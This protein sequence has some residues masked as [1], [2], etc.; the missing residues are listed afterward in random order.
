MKQTQNMALNS[1][2]VVDITAKLKV[3][4]KLKA[5]VKSKSIKGVLCDDVSD[6]VHRVHGYLPE[7][8]TAK[9][10]SSYLFHGGIQ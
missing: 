7:K 6:K 2:V 4:L 9:A 8:I 3:A 1:C 5:H 10:A